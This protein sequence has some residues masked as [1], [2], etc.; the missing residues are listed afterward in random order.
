M[1]QFKY[2]L[3]GNKPLIQELGPHKYYLEYQ[4]HPLDDEAR[5][6]IYWKRDILV[7]QHDNQTIE[8]PTWKQ[9]KEAG[10]LH[11]FE[12]NSNRLHYFFSIDNTNYFGY[13]TN[14]DIQLTGYSF[15]DVTVFRTAK[16]KK[17]A[18]ACITGYQLYDFYINH[19]YCSRCGHVLEH[20]KKE[21]MLQC[22]HCGFMVYP[23]ISP[24][25][26][27]A[28]TH[29]NKLL[30][31]RYANSAPGRYALVA[32]FCEVGET[33][34]ETVVREVMEEVG[35]AVKN[36]VYY[37]SQPWSLSGT[38]LM[39]FFVELEGSDEITLDTSEL[40]EATWMSAE[41]I[42][43]KW[44]DISLTNEMICHFMKQQEETK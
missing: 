24:A 11:Q 6:L 42:P 13:E 1:I 25:V 8:Y 27:V 20:S 38:L 10:I 12:E 43:V 17:E 28:I 40:S 35:L 4:E 30:L 29:Q 23:K 14:V 32:G 7:K 22:E 39:G 9:I 41:E 31:T 34:E 21:R 5:M 19:Q 15:C 2:I 3:K 26:I 16:P 37:K 36:P 33:V 18:F 44:D